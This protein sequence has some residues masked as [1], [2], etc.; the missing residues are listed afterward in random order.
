MSG[1]IIFWIA[2]KV[3]GKVMTKKSF[4]RMLAQIII[5]SILGGF[6]YWLPTETSAFIF[7]FVGVILIDIYG[8]LIDKGKL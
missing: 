6:A 7:G 2:I 1:L 8:I 4:F 3:I 5:I